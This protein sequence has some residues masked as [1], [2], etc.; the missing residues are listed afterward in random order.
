ML[1]KVES[2]SLIPKGPQR[3]MCHF[4]INEIELSKVERVQHGL[5]LM[6]ETWR[7]EMYWFPSLNVY[8]M[9]HVFQTLNIALNESI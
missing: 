5:E 2:S 9:I 7:M 6:S 8:G 3:Q 1:K 4:T